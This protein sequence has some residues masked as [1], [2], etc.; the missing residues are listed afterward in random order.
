MT[1]YARTPKPLWNA[2]RTLARQMRH[3]P[4]PAENHLW[5]H[6]RHHQL[7][8]LQFRRQHSIDRFIVDFYCPAAR[9]IVEID[10]PIHDYTQAEDELRQ[11]FLESMGLRVMRFTNDHVL[12]ETDRVLA[13]IRA[14]VY[15]PHP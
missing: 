14:A 8:G 15:E 6:L 12:M 3:E 2:I 4:T 10:G 11:A 5:Q 7:A 9:L 1:K 13:A